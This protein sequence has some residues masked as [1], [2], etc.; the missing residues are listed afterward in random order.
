MPPHRIKDQLHHNL[1]A[2]SEDMIRQGV[3]EAEDEVCILEEL[4]FGP[5]KK[6][7]KTLQILHMFWTL[8]VM[9]GTKKMELR[10]FT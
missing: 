2:P 4:M 7:K 5:T 9:L 3:D 1:P 10:Y 6:K 8:Y